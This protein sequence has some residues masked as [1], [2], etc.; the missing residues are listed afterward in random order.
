MEKKETS[1]QK[2]KRTVAQKDEQISHFNK[3]VKNLKQLSVGKDVEFAVLKEAFELIGGHEAVDKK[4]AEAKQLKE[5]HEKQYGLMKSEKM[6]MQHLHDKELKVKTELLKD[7]YT[8]AQKGHKFDRT[9]TIDE[10]K[11]K[12]NDAVDKDK[13]Y[14]KMF[15]SIER[16]QKWDKRVEPIKKAAE[17][18][19]NVSKAAVK[20]ANDLVVNPIKK[21]VNDSV[22]VPAN[23]S[24]KMMKE[25]LNKDMELAKNSL[26]KEK[27]KVIGFG[28]TVKAFANKANK[29]LKT[30]VMK[31]TV[32][33]KSQEKEAKNEQE[34]SDIK[35][36]SVVARASMSISESLSDKLSS[37]FSKLK[38]KVT[39]NYK[40][41]VAKT[42]ETFTQHLH[43]EKEKQNEKTKSR[44]KGGAEL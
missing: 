24:M 6:Y 12:I 35:W 25:D 14:A 30:M 13:M 43:A 34:L 19:K 18:M 2:L 9:L 40:D 8:Y 7:E 27:E 37:K 5:K 4:L 41:S 10:R 11:S 21:Q 32:L 39:Q 33:N 26:N 29:S 44:E 1:Y 17:T 38:A 23:L 31:H 42:K 20:T 3:Q 28:K 15:N 22:V 16:K 36:G